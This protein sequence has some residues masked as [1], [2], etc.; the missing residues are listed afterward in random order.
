M[1][2]RHARQGTLAEVGERGQARV[3]GSTATVL[4]SGASAAV[5]A[6]YLAGAG[7]GTLVVATDS[8]AREARDLDSSVAVRVDRSLA[9]PP[10]PPPWAEGMHP[11]ARE[12]AV[13]A[14]RALLLLRRTLTGA[15]P[16]S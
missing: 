7:V 9:P 10:P 6:R 8:I 2:P 14:Y 11:A 16:A 12:V 5:E 4:G 13:G 3:G 1:K 15:D